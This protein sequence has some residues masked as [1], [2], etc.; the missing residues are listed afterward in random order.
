MS[1]ESIKQFETEIANFF[2]SPYA[3]AIDCCTHGIELCLRYKNIKHY[4]VPKRTYISVPFLAQK[5]GVSFEWREE[6]WQDYY[7][8]GGTNIIDA[9]DRDWETE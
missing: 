4:S 2:G 1:F 6:D 8:L 3:V 5:I 9:T 7:Y